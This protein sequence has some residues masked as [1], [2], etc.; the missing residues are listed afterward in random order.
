MPETS[1]EPSRPST[2]RPRPGVAGQKAIQRVISAYH[3]PV[4]RAYAWGRFQIFRQR[5]LDEIGQYLPDRGTAIDVGCGFGL[6]ALYYAQLH[7]G[8]EIHGFDLSEKRI[9]MAQRAAKEIGVTNVVFRVDDARNITRGDP[10]SPVRGE[11]RYSGAYLL[12]IVHHVP[13]ESVAPM[14]AELHRAL[15]PGAHLLVK[16]LDTSPAW[17]RVFAHGLDLAMSPTSPVRYWSNEE[18][19]S[20][21]VR[22]GY[23]VKQHAMVDYLPYPHVL[24][25]CTKPG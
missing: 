2:T 11:G 18:L 5:F 7:P 3:H 4:V 14:L 16:D 17:Q 8:L 15:A 6:F 22:T 13:E 20:L 10:S 25:V 1:S 21:L 9:E 19:S 23:E 12:D 24:Y